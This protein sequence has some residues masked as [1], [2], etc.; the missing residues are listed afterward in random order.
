MHILYTYIKNTKSQCLVPDVKFARFS[1]ENKH[2]FSWGEP[3]AETSWDK[4]ICK[5]LS[6]CKVQSTIRPISYEFLISDANPPQP[7]QNANPESRII[8]TRATIKSLIYHK[9]NMCLLQE[10]LHLSTITY[11]CEKNRLIKLLN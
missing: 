11:Q 10:R 9:L 6:Y 8:I 2:H 7:N 5:C 1:T 4:Y 3:T